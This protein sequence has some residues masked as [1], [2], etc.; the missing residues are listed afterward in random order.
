MYVDH[1]KRRNTFVVRW[2][3]ANGKKCRDQQL[4]QPLIW[5]T[6]TEANRRMKELLKQ[7]SNNALGISKEILFKEAGEIFMRLHGP[8]LAHEHSRKTYQS[9]VNC[10]M[11]VFAKKV[12]SRITYQDI[13]TYWDAQVQAGFKRT[14]IKKRVTLLHTMYDRFKFWNGMVPEVMPEKVA[15]PELN[16]ASVA[17]EYLGNRKTSTYNCGRKRR[18][19]EEELRIAKAWCLANEQEF[20][21][22]ALWQGIQQAIWTAL[23]KSDQKKLRPGESVNVIQEKTQRPQVMPITLSEVPENLEWRWNLLRAAM[24]WMKAPK[25]MPENPRHTTWHDL[26]H[27]APSWLADADFSG[28]V[29]S[30]YLGHTNEKQARTYTHPSGSALVPAVK[31]IEDK[32]AAL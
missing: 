9:Q 31:F 10:L 2:R 32:L 4:G 30:Q 8:R 13:A 18:L 15:L 29:I 5:A 19:S 25:G 17:M 23:R 28:Q 6:R 22:A 24:G 21:T 3:D 20:S 12:F 26:R 16:P 1:D 7:G 27:C 11:M 14:T